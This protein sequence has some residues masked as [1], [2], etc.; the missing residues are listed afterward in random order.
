MAKT[1]LFVYGRLQTGYD[2][3]DSVSA[4]TVDAV[5]G[6]M[7]DRD[8]DPALINPGFAN[9]PWCWGQLLTIDEKELASIDESED[10]YLRQRITTFHGYRAWIY[11]Y[12]GAPPPN[13][14]WLTRWSGSK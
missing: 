6:Y 3:P 14:E 10:G 13:A 8:D 2:P 1:L 4:W 9:E 7:F 5:R 11:A 12:T